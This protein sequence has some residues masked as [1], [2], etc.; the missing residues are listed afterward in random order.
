[1]A[2]DAAE[3]FLRDEQAGTDPAFA[4]IASVRL[5]LPPSLYKCLGTTNIIE[6][7]Q[8]GVQ[9]KTHNLGGHPKPANS[10]HLKT[11]Q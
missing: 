3:L 9:K 11:G 7:P 4:L 1:M 10:G 8:G 2:S 6:S 5:K